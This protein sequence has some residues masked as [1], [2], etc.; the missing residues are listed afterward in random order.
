MSELDLKNLNELS[1]D[2]LISRAAAL[3]VSRPELLTRVELRDEIVRLTETDE[4][5]RQRAR[6]WLGV[7]RDMV[8]SVVEQRLNL[9]DA[10]DL[11]RGVNVRLPRNVPPVA[12][13]TLA[14]IYAAQGHLA[15]AVKLL[16]EVL[17]REPD[18]EAAR[19]LRERLS[20]DVA[21]EA[22]SLSEPPESH[23]DLEGDSESATGSEP[24]ESLRDQVDL[25][26]SP[27]T[28]SVADTIQHPA[29]F[30]VSDVPGAPMPDS[31]APQIEIGPVAVAEPDDISKSIVNEVLRL[32]PTVVSG[33]V[34]HDYLIYRRNDDSV[35]CHWSITSAA[36][37][38]WS[39]R[40]DGQWVLRIIQVSPAAGPLVPA[41]TVVPLPG[42]TGEAILNDVAARQ[43][44]RMAGGWET[45]GRFV[46]VSI[47]IEVAG[48]SPEEAS[49]A[50]LPLPGP[51]EPTPEVWLDFARRDWRFLMVGAAP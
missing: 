29:A 3:G 42:M 33:E 32:E 23:D 18:H 4:Q 12:T 9:P 28:Y 39:E 15:R 34:E 49:I 37:E 20:A 40:R 24:P 48:S 35:V 46:P 21:P 51:N 45:G 7:A 38:S 43:Q 41:E 27:V 8:A 50:W 11:I 1:R 2:E 30:K 17:T 36:W 13:V 44:L 10:A 14:E 5:Q 25:H 47:G 19:E 16:D 22:A 6:G 31:L 26:V